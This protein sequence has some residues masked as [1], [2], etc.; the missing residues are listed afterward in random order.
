MT[1]GLFRKGYQVW[2]QYIRFDDGKIVIYFI[3]HSTWII[4]LNSVKEIK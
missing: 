3:F 2:Y 1:I 4:L